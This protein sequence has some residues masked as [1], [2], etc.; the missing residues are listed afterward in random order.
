LPILGRPVHAHALRHSFDSRL[1]E[2]GAAVDFI[3]EALGRASIQTTMIYAHLSSLKR[4]AEL[5]KS[6]A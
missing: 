3:R 5:E 4:R 2:N 6:F 1:R